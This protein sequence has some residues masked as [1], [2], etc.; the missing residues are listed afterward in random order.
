VAV[1]EVAR[2]A[3]LVVVID[4]RRQYEL[5]VFACEFEF[6]FSWLAVLIRRQLVLPLSPALVLG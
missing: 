2:C 5:L 1:A 3:E 4:Y 6:V